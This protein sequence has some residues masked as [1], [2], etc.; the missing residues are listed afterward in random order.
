[1]QGD[2]FRPGHQLQ[3]VG[4][5]GDHVDGIADN[6]LPAQAIGEGVVTAAGKTEHRGSAGE[7]LTIRRGERSGLFHCAGMGVQAA[8]AGLPGRRREGRADGVAQSVDRRM[9]RRFV[10]AAHTAEE[11]RGSGC[12]LV[13]LIAMRDG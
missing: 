2:A 1:M 10:A 11:Q 9:Q 4:A 13:M 6:A 3:P 5:F 7:R 12:R 8:A